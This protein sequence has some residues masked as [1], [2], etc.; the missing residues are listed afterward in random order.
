MT[1][2]QTK[3]G[4]SY[5]L[6]IIAVL[7]LLNTY[8]LIISQNLV[9]RSKQTSMASSVSMV[10][11]ALSDLTTLTE[12]NVS[13]AL[14]G[15]EETGVSR[16]MVTD[17]AGRVLYDT[18]EPGSAVGLYAFYTEIAQALN[19]NDAFYCCYDSTAFL[20]RGASPVV[21]RSQTVG[22]IYAYEYDTEQAQLLKSFQSNL[23]KISFM[24]ALLVMGLSAVLSQMLT[25]Q[26]SELL[27]AIRKVREGAYSHRAA[28]KGKDEIGQIAAE[29][30]SLTDRLQ[31]TEDAR[32]RFVSDAS[33]ELKTPLAGIRLLSDSI[34]Q[35]KNMDVSTVREFV[36]DI[37]EEAQR[38]ERITED[39]LRLTRLDSDAME[40]AEPVTVTPVLK[41]VIRMLSLVAQERE[42]SLSYETD[43]AAVVLSTEDEMQQIIYNL[44]ENAIKYSAPMGFVH[45]NL[46]VEEKTAV[47]S[48]EDNGIGIPDED[49][50]H[51]FERFYRVDKNRSRAVGGTGLG[52]S[53][54]SDT[55]KRRGGTIEAAHRQAG[56]GT[57]FT[58]RLPQA[59]EGEA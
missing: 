26:I 40:K 13:Q 57:I 42:I 50:G 53:I 33:H 45:L 3:F 9:F 15:I 11:A 51:I 21:Y 16:I 46:R 49:M 8:P 35:T 39:L 32:R 7:I 14:S 4:L 1:S 5:I 22:A 20:S 54:V 48:V 12:D 6:I 59:E 56:P 41:R 38:L 25:R 31:V 36:G 24:I 27:Q 28:V 43:G 37:G 23:M 58:V 30:N 29:F 34:L 2:L 55:I 10:E 19:G 17:T 47:L 52:L 18:R 44:T